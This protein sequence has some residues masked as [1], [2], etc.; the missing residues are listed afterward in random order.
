MNTLTEENYLK[1]I[2]KISLNTSDGITTSA[3]ADEMKTK[4]ATVTD[5]L[6]KLS[7]K[8]LID[9]EKYYGVKMT[10]KGKKVALKIVRKHR[11]W[12]LFLV[13]ILDFKWDEVHVIAEQLEHIQSD[14]L[15]ARI[16]KFL[17]HPKT[18]PH[19]DPIPDQNGKV[20][21]THLIS[22]SQLMQKSSGE[23]S[24][25]TEH[26]PSFLQYLEKNGLNLGNNIQVVEKHEFDKSIDIKI[27][28]RKSLHI[29]ND[30]AKNIMI[31]T[32]EQK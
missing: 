16:D 3:I 14:E 9:Y 24:G 32:H 28:R 26:S 30:I 7:E 18:D 29:S 6:K 25:V 27:N 20:F 1:C 21:S 22:L 23:I 11:L 19:G 2:Y 5:M 31:S 13:K 15:I 12:E 17:G 8:N 10:E 4:S